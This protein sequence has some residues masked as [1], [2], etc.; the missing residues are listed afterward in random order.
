[1]KVILS[2][3]AGFC[4]GVKRAYE[5]VEKLSKDSQTKKPIVVLGLL[6]HNAD[7]VKRIEGMGVQK[8]DFSGNVEDIEDKI[9]EK[10]GTLVVTAHG[11]GP[12]I[13]EIARKKGVDI[14][15][16]TCPKVIKVQR[17]SQVF[18][19]RGDQIVIIGEKKHKEVQGIY[20]WSQKKASIVENENDVENLNLDENR[21][22]MVVS[23]TTQIRDWV[24][25][26]SK[27]V[28]KKYSKSQVYETVCDTTKDRQSEV[29][30][31]AK[32]NDIVFVIGS[33]ESS[34]SNRLYEIAKEINSNTHFIE[35][36][37]DINEKWLQGK[38]TAAVTAGASS[39]DWII[40]EVIE[41]LK[42]F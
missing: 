19:N 1:M 9:D 28:C 36:V 13:F 23:Q 35:R 17:L 12:E 20:G 11:I 3:Y 6:V 27:A 40:D 7:V 42:N 31:V 32:N 26:I 18:L 41:F 39:P 10:I 8:I 34:N 5:I 2:K 14:V 16:T 38:N 15:D 24:N 25:K 4:G 29:A 30:E 21:N 33:P 22:I 37:G